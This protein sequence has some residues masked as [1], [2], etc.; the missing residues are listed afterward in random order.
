[1]SFADSIEAE[2][3]KLEQE[4]EAYKNKENLPGFWALPV[5]DVS[6][7]TVL[8]E[9]LRVKDFGEG[10]RRIFA[11]EVNGERKDWAINPKNPL[12]QE[13]VYKLSEGYRV[14]KVL[15]KGDKAQTRYTLKDAFKLEAKKKEGEGG[16]VAPSSN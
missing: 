16:A 15:R 13:I 11:V 2:K 7:F 6:V 3:I 9:D 5:D 12:Y 4:A 14:F 8:E 10:E 1:M